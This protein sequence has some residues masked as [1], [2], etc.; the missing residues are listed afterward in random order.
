MCKAVLPGAGSCLLEQ[1]WAGVHRSQSA[2]LLD[3]I[4]PTLSARFPQVGRTRTEGAQPSEP[5]LMRSLFVPCPC[6]DLQTNQTVRTFQLGEP[7]MP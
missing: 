4:P 7:V 1:T 6:L 2:D 5:T 3:P